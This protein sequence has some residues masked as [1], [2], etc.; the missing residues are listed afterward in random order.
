MYDLKVN[1]GEHIVGLFLYTTKILGDIVTIVD[2]D[3]L[4]D[5]TSDNI[6]PRAFQTWKSP[7]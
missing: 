2:V 1:P 4:L 6:H 5:G 3:I 7:V